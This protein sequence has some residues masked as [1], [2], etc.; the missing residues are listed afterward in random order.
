MARSTSRGAVELQAYIDKNYPRDG[1]EH[2]SVSAFASEKGLDRVQVLR[3]LNGT[4]GSRMTVKLAVA[5]E[6]ATGGEVPVS[7]WAED[8]ETD[9]SSPVASTDE[10]GAA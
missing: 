4:R 5:V 2:G 9:E 3:V 1:E 10:K 6:A 7:M 8:I